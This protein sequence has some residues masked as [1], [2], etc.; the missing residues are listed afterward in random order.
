MGY[1]SLPN[2]GQCEV[3]GL[4]CEFVRMSMAFVNRVL[5]FFFFGAF[6]MVKQFGFS[7]L[8]KKISIFLNFF[9]HWRGQRPV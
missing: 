4:L 1:L 3:P 2:I 8:L 5:P 9:I 6:E 7:L